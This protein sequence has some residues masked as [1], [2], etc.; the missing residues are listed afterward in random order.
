[1]FDRDIKRIMA[2]IN[3]VEQEF[4]EKKISK[5]FQTALNNA[6]KRRILQNE[7]DFTV[8]ETL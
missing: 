1:M 7:H 5:N 8:N 4:S 6:Y 3:G 2:I